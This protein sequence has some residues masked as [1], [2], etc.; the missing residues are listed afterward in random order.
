MRTLLTWVAS[1]AEY[2]W[3]SESKGERVREVEVLEERAYE[4]NI[5][6]A[7]KRRLGGL[8]LAMRL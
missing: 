7:P 6:A 3:D 1:A 2:Q 4:K 8:D 5:G